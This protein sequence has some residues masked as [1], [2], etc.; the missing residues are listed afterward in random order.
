MMMMMTMK[1]M[2]LV[3]FHNLF[4]DPIDD[5]IGITFLA[6]LVREGLLHPLSK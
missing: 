6:P 4:E 5:L 3:P 1:L 2:L